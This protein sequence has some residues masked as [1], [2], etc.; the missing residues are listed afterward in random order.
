MSDPRIGTQLGGYEIDSLLGHGGMG[1]VYKARHLRLGRMVALKV[2]APQYSA[3]ETFR[4]RFVREAEM[5]ASIDHPNVIPVYDADEVDGVLYLA[6]R[7]VE[8]TDLKN[9]ISTDGPMEIESVLTVVSQIAGALDAAHARGLI[10]RD[11]KPANVLIATSDTG[12]PHVYLTD[13]GLTKHG[14]SKS[15]LTASGAFVGTI[16]YI[17]PEQIEGKSVDARSDIYAFGCV[18]YECLTGQV[19]FVKETDV[20][21]MYAHMM[22]PRP[23]VSEARSGLP[24]AVDAVLEKAMAR[25]PAE[26]HSTAT[27]LVTDLRNALSGQASPAAVAPAVTNEE[28][29]ADDVQEIAITKLVPA[30]RRRFSRLAI[31]MIVA[32]FMGVAVAL[33]VGVASFLTSESDGGPD[34]P[35][36]PSASVPAVDPVPGD[37][38]FVAPDGADGASGAS[39]DPVASL[40]EAVAMAGD[41]GTVILADGTYKATRTPMLLIDHPV[42]IRGA[43]GAAPVLQGG[44]AHP[45]AIRIAA[46]TSD[47]TL[48]NLKF[49]GFLGEGLKVFCSKCEDAI[50]NRD[51]TLEELEFTAGGTP[52]TIENVAGMTL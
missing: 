36:A 29:P 45:D 34:R 19:P 47:V 13:F 6:M 33:F 5:A 12:P 39:G 24:V 30:P 41:G 10:H 40:S 48:A 4:A 43:T 7:Y 22:D 51:I 35:A 28:L 46:G 16:D 31:T 9:M 20:A 18:L 49:D 26:R 25:D 27:E 37:A 14:S 23:L 15:G 50:E 42:T 3:D 38:V 21:V 32:L 44:D 1:V 52:L 17:A 2:L 11:I 8:G